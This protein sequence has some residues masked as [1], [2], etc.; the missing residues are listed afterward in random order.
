MN[1]LHNVPL[2]WR[3]LIGGQVLITA[4]LMV[5]RMETINTM[6]EERKTAGGEGRFAPPAPLEEPDRA[7]RRSEGS[8]TEGGQ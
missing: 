1:A 2:K 4:G 7:R 3:L 6:K 8:T 5:H